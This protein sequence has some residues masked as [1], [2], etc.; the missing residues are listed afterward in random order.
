MIGFIDPTK[1]NNIPEGLIIPWASNLS[2]PPSGWS[3]YTDPNSGISGFSGSYILGA[4]LTGSGGSLS[5]KQ[6]GIIPGNTVYSLRSGYQTAPVGKV[7]AVTTEDGE[8]GKF[9]AY[10]IPYCFTY[11]S[12]TP[13]STSDP[14][15]R[16]AVGRVKGKHSHIFEI[17]LNLNNI[18]FQFIKAI[19]KQEKIPQNGVLLTTIHNPIS[20]QSLGLTQL[21][22]TGYYL[23]CNNKYETN[24]LNIIL[25]QV[26]SIV[27]NNGEHNHS[28]ND[29]YE[30]L[31][32]GNTESWFPWNWVNSEMDGTEGYHVHKILNYQFI[33]NIKKVY[34]TAW[35]NTSSAYNL[36]SGMFAFWD[37]SYNTIPEGWQLAD[38]TNGTVDMRNYYIY[39]GGINQQNPLG[40]RTGNN[41]CSILPQTNSNLLTVNNYSWDEIGY[42]MHFN[43]EWVS[44]DSGYLKH[45]THHNGQSIPHSHS[46]SKFKDFNYYPHYYTLYVIQKL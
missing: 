10:N 46:E 35:T 18:T 7:Y 26:T 33:D 40:T 15:R 28:W 43:K 11:T 24:N 1:Y 13:T 20:L 23:K 6:K 29:V 19:T 45:N 44:L 17:T 12:T 14:N 30:P 25:N 31:S 4:D 27:N 41:T 22:L 2:T 34:T 3:L 37:G 21:G 8:H 5:A 36:F 16:R 42:H 9:G 38:G 32:S 39:I